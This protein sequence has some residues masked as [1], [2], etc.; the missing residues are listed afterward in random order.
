MASGGSAVAL[1]PYCSVKARLAAPSM[2]SS[3]TRV[4][5]TGLH[6]RRIWLR[7]VVV[8]PLRAG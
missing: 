1:V 3:S 5:V 6:A 4:T 2:D 8:V 7:T